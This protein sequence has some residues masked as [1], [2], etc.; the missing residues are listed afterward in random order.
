MKFIRTLLFFIILLPWVVFCVY[1][2]PLNHNKINGLKCSANVNFHLSNE[3]HDGPILHG[4]I[5][6]NLKRND[7]DGFLSLSGMVEWQGVEY[8]VSRLVNVKYKSNDGN[9]VSI[10]TV[11]STSLSQD[12]SPANIIETFF[13]GNTSQPLRFF[14]IKKIFKNAYLVGN[15]NSPLMICVDR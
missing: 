10:Y 11:N 3:L 2:Y 6:I 12:K 1:I 15:V 5:S 13:M 14:K 9:Y 7:S 8:P 4:V